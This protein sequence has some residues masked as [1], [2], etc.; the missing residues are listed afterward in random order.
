MAY[1]PPIRIC[2][3]THHS[4][5]LDDD[6]RHIPPAIYARLQLPPELLLHSSW[7]SRFRLLWM[8][9][10]LLEGLGLSVGITEPFTTL[11]I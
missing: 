11:M 8:L 7:I 9:I 2:I 1:T 4:L 10:I 5:N 3:C 6:E